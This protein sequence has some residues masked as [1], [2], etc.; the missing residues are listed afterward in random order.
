MALF[1]LQP[2][3]IGCW[4]ALIP[5]VKTDLGLSKLALAIALLGMPSALL[6]ALQFA[7]KVVARLGLRRMM[8]LK[9][10]QGR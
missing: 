4:L 6:I 5:F 2:M 3:A 8:L 7:G 9:S 1:C 10:G